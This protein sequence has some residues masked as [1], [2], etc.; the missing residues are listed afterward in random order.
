MTRRTQAILSHLLPAIFWTLAI[1]GSL[2]PFVFDIPRYAWGYI[3]I[4]IVLFCIVKL[5]GIQRHTS[6]VNVCFEVALLIGIAS[7]WL[8]TVL[9]LILPAWA[10]LIYINVFSVQSITATLIGLAT[11]AVWAFVFIS[12]G[13]IANPWAEFF[14][15]K[16]AWGWIPTGAILLAWLAST[17]VRRNLR[18]R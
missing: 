8:P 16:N 11:V 14:A 1:G 10:Y 5:G 15:P 3:P 9:F 4:A 17:I 13:W 2:I 7:Y 18:V 6:S 12:M